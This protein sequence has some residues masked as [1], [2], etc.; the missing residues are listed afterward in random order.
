ME[1]EKVLINRGDKLTESRLIILRYLK[2]EKKIISAQALSKKIKSVDRASVYRTLN[3]L[4][5]LHLVNVEMINKEKLY[6]LAG[7]PHHHII[8]YNCGYIESFPCNNYEYKK[9][10][11][12]TN[13][14]HRL[15]LIGLCNK[16]SKKKYE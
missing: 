14:T 11:N 8:C 9:F 3:L 6:C 10:N 13:I 1:I 7:H 16:C 12:F 4:E 5:E 2:K 15:T